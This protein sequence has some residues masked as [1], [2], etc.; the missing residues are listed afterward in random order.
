MFYGTLGQ[1]KRGR[2]NDGRFRFGR[3]QRDG[4]ERTSI[5]ERIWRYLIRDVSS[6]S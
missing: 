1:T 2:G 3:H 6:I 5:V 4:L